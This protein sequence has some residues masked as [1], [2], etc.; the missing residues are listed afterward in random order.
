ML[1]QQIQNIVEN[2]MGIHRTN[3]ISRLEN[4]QACR[5]VFHQ[6]DEVTVT[7]LLACNV[8]VLSARISLIRVSLLELESGIIEPAELS[9]SS[10]TCC[11]TVD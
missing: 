7:H 8:L 11:W 2:P 10:L 5:K 9:Q 3:Y 1:A 4:I 6:T